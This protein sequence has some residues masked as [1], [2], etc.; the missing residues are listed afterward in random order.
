M[1][2]SFPLLYLALARRLLPLVIMG[3]GGK[4]GS[5]L[6]EGGL[7]VGK[8][9]GVGGDSLLGRNHNRVSAGLNPL[10]CTG[11]HERGLEC[12]CIFAEYAP[13][14]DG[15]CVVGI[16]RWRVV[17]SRAGWSNVGPKRVG[18]RQGFRVAVEM[19]IG[20]ECSALTRCLATLAGL[21]VWLPHRLTVDFEKIL[22]RCM[23]LVERV[24]SA[25]QDGG[26][27]PQ[28]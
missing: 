6:L 21:V 25:A 1:P 13:A 8:G 2:R 4:G 26:G 15:G 12:L 9:D 24:F 14:A 27:R 23:V 18:G 20:S 10:Q 22:R 16:R 7:G 5:G 11:P 3:H 28:S 19:R 17:G